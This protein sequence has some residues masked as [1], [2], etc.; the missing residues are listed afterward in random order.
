MVVLAN[1]NVKLDR[2]VKTKDYTAQYQADINNG[3][4]PDIVLNYVKAKRDV[5]KTFLE[6][7]NHRNVK[8]RDNAQE[9]E[10]FVSQCEAF[11]EKIENEM[12]AENSPTL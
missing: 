4:S 9:I 11:I 8:D 5:M 1:V 2:I 3:M 10:K 7:L 12:N 6:T